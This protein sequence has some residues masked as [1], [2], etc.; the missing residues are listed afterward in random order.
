MTTYLIL[1]SISAWV[2]YDIYALVNDKKGDM[3]TEVVRPA[4]RAKASIPFAAGFVMGHL[5]W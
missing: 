5:F 2:A 1:I 4:A 3:I